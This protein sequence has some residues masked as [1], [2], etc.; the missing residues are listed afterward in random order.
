MKYWLLA[1]FVFLGATFLHA[2]EPAL[3]P[4][5]AEIRMGKGQFLITPATKLVAQDAEDQ[6][7][8]AFFSDYI[9]QQYGFSLRLVKQPV[10][11]AIRFATRHFIQKPDKDGYELRIDQTGVVVE[12]DTYAGTFYGLQSLL[13]LLPV[14]VPGPKPKPVLKGRPSA[15][16]ATPGHALPQL[17][18]KDAPRFAWRGMHLDVSRHFF[19]ASFIKKYI[20]LLAAHK[21]NYF[22]WHL[23]DDQGWRIEVRRYP[24]LTATGAW[25]HGTITGRYPGTGNDDRRYGGYYTQAEIRDIVRYA[26]ERFVT[27]LP[28][29]DVPGHSSAAIAAYPWLSCFPQKPTLIPSWPSAGSQQAQAAGKPKQ[30]QETWGV[31]EDVL[32]AGNDSTYTFL[33]GVLAEVLDLFPSTYIHM[34]GDEAPIIH[35]KQCP[36][37]QA[38]IRAEGLKDEHGLQAYFMRRLEAFL[39]A[40]GRTLVGWDEILEGGLA[41][42]AA[43]M[44]W[45]GER[46]GIEA[47]RQKHPVIMTP[48][49]PLYFDHAQT[50]TED[51]LVRGGFNPLDSVYAYEVIPRSLDSTGASFILGAQ[52]NVWTEYMSN[53]AK[54]EYMVL[55]RMAAF[56]ETV[57]TP[58]QRR[59]W[60]SFERRLPELFARYDRM[61]ATASRAVYFLVPDLQRDAAGEGVLLRFGSRFPN[62]SI[63]YTRSRT[64]PMQ[65]Y[66]GGIPINK[67][68]SVIAELV[69]PD[70]RPVHTVAYAFTMG[71]AAGKE[72]RLQVGPNRSYPGQGAFSLVNGL[73]SDRGLSFPDWLGFLG[74]DIDATIDLGKMDTLSQVR[75]HT[76]DQNGSWIYLPSY[77]EVQISNDG[78]QFMTIGQSTEFVRDHPRLTSGWIT[79]RF[80]QIKAQYVR[81][82]ARNHGRI[83]EG[84]PGA[85]TKAWLFADEI[86]VD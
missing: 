50:K 35:W 10:S 51:S 47:A 23:T 83:G 32:C 61:G 42:N 62:P 59:D 85:G 25:R 16:V 58:R 12:G 41:P 82:I 55:P 28:E 84:K 60:G 26:Q 57:W 52:A 11:K 27:V 74:N 75:M 63:R 76:L 81:V 15:P 65:P 2:Q 19:P 24:A 39:N 31:F 68:D 20:D 67:S 71:K 7:I 45:R 9:R 4:R 14:P 29:I 86:Q 73:I 17:R 80:P 8:A 38:R 69:G 72:A 43:V 66:L 54:V 48:E 70:G 64:A 6:R 37:C 44:S 40:R 56:A 77:M 13:Q 30:V 21:L 33:E 22:H 46:G 3:F 78:Q 36:L 79:V 53:P 1:V 5:P 49:K 34:G 18:I